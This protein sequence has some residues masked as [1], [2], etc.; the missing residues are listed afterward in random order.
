MEFASKYSRFRGS[1][2]NFSSPNA[3]MC[4]QLHV[5]LKCIFLNRHLLAVGTLY[6]HNVHF[7]TFSS[8][9]IADQVNNYDPA[10]LDSPHLI[11]PY[12]LREL[13]VASLPKMMITG[14]IQSVNSPK[15]W[16]WKMFRNGHCADRVF[17]QLASACL[18]RCI[19]VL[20]F[21]MLKWHL[22][23]EY[24]PNTKRNSVWCSHIWHQNIP[25]TPLTQWE[26]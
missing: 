10:Y 24:S 25:L 13:L 23:L 8:W 12:R 1:F 20:H 6:L 22:K 26:F 5:T 17:L 9:A 18:K 14:K 3:T 4:V 21:S 19:L 15:E 16:M 2:R 7:W 11:N